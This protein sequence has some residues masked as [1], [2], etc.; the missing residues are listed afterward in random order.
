[1]YIDIL[2]NKEGKVGAVLGKKSDLGI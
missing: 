1:M 2:M